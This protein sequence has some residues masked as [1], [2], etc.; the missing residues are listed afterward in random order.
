MDLANL[1]LDLSDPITLA[2]AIGAA[3]AV[4]IV[5]LLILALRG[6]ARS[7]RAAEPLIY[8]MDQL[9]RALSLIHI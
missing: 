5:I 1:P 3:L 9:G 6:V 2:L 7:A 8:Q 4:L